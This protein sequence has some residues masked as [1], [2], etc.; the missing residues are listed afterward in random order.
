MSRLAS[1]EEQPLVGKGT[2]DMK[3]L[4]KALPVLLLGLFLQAGGG[5]VG[6]TAPA[7]EPALEVSHL[8]ERLRQ[9]VGLSG[10][11]VQMLD[12]RQELA[13]L[14]KRDHEIVVPLLAEALEAPHDGTPRDR[15]YRLAVIGVLQDI[16]EAAQAAVPVLIEITE[17]QAE[18]N[19]DAKFAAQM[20]LA[21]IG[22][23]QAED[24][25]RRAAIRTME[26]W[27]RTAAP[28]E[29]DRAVRHN[30]FFIRQQLRQPHP[31]EAMVEASVLNLL[32]VGEAAREAGPVLLQAYQDRRI[33]EELR[34]VIV[35][36]LGEIGIANTAL[37]ARQTQD[38]SQP[39]DRLAAVIADTRS[40]DELI[41]GLAMTELGKLGPSE[42]AIEALIDALRQG[43]NPGDA[44]R[45]L[46]QFGPEA[47]AAAPHLLPYLH[48][49]RAASNAIQTLALIGAGDS[50]I[51][52]AL[53][54]VASDENSPNRGLAA[55]ALGKLSAGSS[56]STLVGVLAD[57]D[58]YTRILAARALGDMGEA[59]RDAVPPLTTLLDDPDKD[60]RRAAA[61]ALGKIGPPA[62]AAVPRL[63]RQLQ[64]TDARLKQSALA[65]LGRIGGPTATAALREDAARY[66]EADRA[67][68]R[69]LRG[70]GERETLFGFVRR[71]PEARG[72]QVARAMMEDPDT[73][74]AYTG[75]GFLIRA[76]FEEETVPVLARIVATGGHDSELG[77]RIGWDWLHG[78]DSE[79]MARMMV[80]IRGYLRANL[81]GFSPDERTR[82]RGFL[83]AA[84]Q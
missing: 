49:A 42:A 35:D 63:T 76:G 20:A 68:Y 18:G 16:G 14:G 33:G 23:P 30:D 46:G 15:A 65:A 13:Q 29:V 3:T 82:I 27:L 83:D 74:I 84:P 44:A 12:T 45:I 6:Q 7:A 19:H 8:L 56:L 69:R 24:A 55:S 54:R 66:A 5:L 62:A 25:E 77:G 48:D 26:A 22:T 2:F 43:R 9:S 67:E 28:A 47:K 71:L 32:A 59:G 41:S 57:P 60:V 38:P 51:I 64:S 50:E 53:S 81:D 78:G 34:A 11:I 58:K 70:T 75:C 31:S 40:D 72:L 80:R 21:A 79:L 10:D 73:V 17:D 52:D 1:G 37:A 4:S 61:E 39:L 36:A